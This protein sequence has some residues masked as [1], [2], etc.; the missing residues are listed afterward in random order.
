MH[1]LIFTQPPPFALTGRQCARLRGAGPDLDRHTAPAPAADTCRTGSKRNGRE[2]AK[3]RK[4]PVLG[5]VDYGRGM[6]LLG[7]VGGSE[8]RGW[9]GLRLLV[10]VCVCVRGIISQQ[11]YLQ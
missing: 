8:G 11:W 3:I 1:E 2:T 6:V 7:G 4:V 10:C 9:E 5:G